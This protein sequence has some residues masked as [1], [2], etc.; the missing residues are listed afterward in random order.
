M[1]N[2]P[3]LPPVFAPGPPTTPA[4]E[5]GPTTFVPYN[6]QTQTKTINIANPFPP[7]ELGPG[8]ADPN[9][10]NVKIQAPSGNGY[11]PVGRGTI[12]VGNPAAGGNPVGTAQVRFYLGADGNLYILDN[13]SGQSFVVQPSPNTPQPPYYSPTRAS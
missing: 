12:G 2:P 4:W 9:I 7:M 8:P 5:S 11:G 13:K 10:S 6:G 1:P 3:F